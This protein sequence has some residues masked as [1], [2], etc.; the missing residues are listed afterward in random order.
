MTSR[1]WA[2][3]YDTTG[4][5]EDASK[6]VTVVPS[7]NMIL[8]AVRTWVVFVDDPAYTSLVM[9][10]YANN[11]VDD[12]PSYV[13]YT[14]TDVRTKAEIDP[15]SNGNGFREI[16]FTFDDISLRAG[17]KYHFVLNAVDYVPS[18]DNSRLA[19]RKGFP[20]PVY[21]DGGTYST[22]TI[23]RKGNWLYFIGAKQ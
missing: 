11:A 4:E 10:I 8:R 2:D 6:Y 12:T 17:D 14:S 18:G 16:Y 5:A 21:S 22:A 15:D 7:D 19:W 23:S 20:D 1:I 9:K 13:Q 3:T